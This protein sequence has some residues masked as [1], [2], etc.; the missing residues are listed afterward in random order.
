MMKTT[1]LTMLALLFISCSSGK[2]SYAWKGQ[3]KSYLI[4]YQEMMLKGDSFQ[5]K[6]YFEDAVKEAKNDVSLETLAIVYLSKCAMQVAMSEKTS[7]QEYQKIKSLLVDAKYDSYAKL[8]LKDKDIDVSYLNKY[9]SLYEAILKKEVGLSDIQSLDTVYAQALAAMLVF[10]HGLINEEMVYY[11]I[12]KASSENMK[13][14]MLVW[15]SKAQS[16]VTGEKLLRVKNQ[17]KVLSD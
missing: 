2:V 10:N 16:I 1:L 7:C 9:K 12:D 3:T 15:L 11:M 4:K 13:G 14:L 17:I 8:L 5:A 6:Y